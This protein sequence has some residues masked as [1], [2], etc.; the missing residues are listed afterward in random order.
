M[1]LF[2]DVLWSKLA[3]IYLFKVKNRNTKFEKKFSFKNWKRFFSIIARTRRLIYLDFYSILTALLQLKNQKLIAEPTENFEY[4]FAWSQ[5]VA[6]SLQS[7]STN[8]LYVTLH[9][10]LHFTL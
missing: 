2:T 1:Q 5:F 6:R 3:G 9:Y 8:M 7:I 10:T 4:V